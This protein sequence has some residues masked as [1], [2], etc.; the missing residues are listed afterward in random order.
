VVVC[1]RT[2]LLL[3]FAAFASG[4]SAF[5]GEDTTPPE[6]KSLSFT[7]ASIDTSTQAA[8]VILTFTVT[9]DSSGANYFEA[10]FFDSTGT[11]RQTASARFT[12]TLSATH[13]LRVSFPK[14]SASGT[15]NLANIFLSDAAGNTLVLDAD[16]VR[17]RGF[18]WQL[19]VR[20]S[21]DT[22]SPK[23]ASLEFS[24]S[25]IDTSA[26]AADVKV[27]F[28]ATDDLS[29]VSYLELSFVSPS[30]AVRRGASAKLEAATSVSNSVTVTFP[31]L[32]EP[33]QWTLSALFLSDAAGNTLVLDAEGIVRAG[34]RAGLLVKSAS[35]T[36]PP[37]L[38]SFRFAPEAIDTSQGP[39][40]V[41]VDF[42]ATD[43]FSGV[44]YVEVVFMSATGVKQS[45]AATFKPAAEVNGSVEV[46]FPQ[47][48]ESGVWA[49]HTVVITDDAGNTLVLDAD[50]MASRVAK[51][52]QV[53]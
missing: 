51:Q 43:N 46:G 6:L 9:D 16:G 19:E 44:K 45:A 48:S 14:F 17:G 13:T 21:R 4:G 23:I 1:P 2:I 41:K 53:R 36:V 20:S 32:S 5:A 50:A 37:V 24:P 25:E 28:T 15:W 30:G 3:A 31:R 10:A 29:G 42:T 40:T 18:P 33:G 49:V 8:E 26:G 35:D 52:L 27:N 47:S 39:A 38:T 11:A 7:P 34:L 22:E 12:P